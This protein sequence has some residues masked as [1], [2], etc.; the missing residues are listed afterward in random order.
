ML[1]QYY[2]VRTNSGFEARTE[3]SRQR[4]EEQQH[5]DFDWARRYPRPSAHLTD[6]SVPFVKLRHFLTGDI[7]RPEREVIEVAGEI[8]TD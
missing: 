7:G 1:I 5:F 3:F 4:V 2:I 6:K 8:C